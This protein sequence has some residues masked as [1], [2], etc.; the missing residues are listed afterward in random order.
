MM[1]I[2]TMW[3]L[4]LVSIL[5]FNVE[6]STFLQSATWWWLWA[7]LVSADI[8]WADTTSQWEK[9][10]QP[11]SHLCPIHLA[12]LHRT[13]WKCPIYVVGTY[14]LGSR[15]SLHHVWAFGT[16]S[17]HSSCQAPDLT[18]CVAAAEPLP[19][20]DQSVLEEPCTTV[21]ERLELCQHPHCYEGWWVHE[22]SK[23]P[24]PLLPTAL[25]HRSLQNWASAF[26]PVKF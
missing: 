6:M 23:I 14:T 11:I 13:L 5:P 17:S 22:Q 15:V 25:P 19:W 1:K 20:E 2:V 4:I 9:S 24:E 21:I 18:V 12:W 10:N 8:I 3:A 16:V 7:R 26:K